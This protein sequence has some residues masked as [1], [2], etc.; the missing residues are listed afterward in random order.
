MSNAV[1]IQN[2]L[3]FNLELLNR[4]PK[5]HYISA[6]ELHQ[7]LVSSGYQRSLRTVQRQLE[8][9]ST[10]FNIDVSDQQKP[11][12]YRWAQDAKG[13]SIAQLSQQESLLLRLAEENL[14]PLLP[15]NLMASLKSLFD[16]AQANL[17]QAQPQALNKQW[18]NK[19]RSVP[20]TQPLMP[21]QIDPNVFEA[22]SLAL[23]HNKWLNLDYT[24]RQQKTAQIRVMPLG[25]AQQGAVIYLVCRYQGYTNERSLVLHRIQS[26]KVSTVVFEPP[27]EFNL[28]QYDNDGR[29]GLGEG[30]AICLQFCIT[31]HA[32]MHLLETPL[33]VDQQIIKHLEGY[34]ITAT[35]IDTLQLTWWLNGFGDQVHSI[36]KTPIPPKKV[37]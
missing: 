1:P 30:Q 27:S 26:A 5:H 6:K 33:S 22:V 7:Q 3:L 15:A 36:T 35:V 14:K 34:Q 18:L 17:A 4:I 2:N 29:F 24:N 23:Y 31:H 21:A 16:Q 19:V 9:L 12:G 8:V 32:G 20:A 28:E 11:Y 13:V 10:Q 25:L 37:S